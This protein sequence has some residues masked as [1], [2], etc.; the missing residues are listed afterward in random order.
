MSNQSNVDVRKIQITGGSSFMITLPK[1]WADSVGLKKNDAIGLLPQSDGSLVLY[2]GGAESVHQGTKKV[3]SADDQNDPDFLYRQ[4]VG[5]YIAGHSSIEIVSETDIPSSVA[6]IASSFTQTAIG[7]EIMEE[8]DDH[9]LIQDLMDQREMRPSKSVERM[10]VLVRNMLNDALD[11]LDSKDA[12]VLKN[13]QERDREV[14]R[15]DWLVSRQVNI[16]QK[17]I[18]ISRKMGMDICEISRCA[19]ISRSIERIGDHA[20]LLATNLIPVIDSG[21]PVLDEK[22]LS[23]GRE[24]VKLFTDSVA[25]W[26]NKDMAAANA[27][28]ERGEDLV[29]RALAIGEIDDVVD[30][31]TAVAAELIAG[32]V[33]RVTEYSMDIAEIAINS[34]MD[35]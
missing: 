31:R 34:A 1:E 10:K 35:Q 11:T 13:Y 15:L 3:I 24:A 8:S 22:I 6:N 32:S 23:A 5:A 26:S 2:P 28:I 33:K 9:V 18:T 12:S 19:T 14:D 27:C 29:K 17:D 21:L 25:T 16:H 30:E 4:L 7:L 20:V